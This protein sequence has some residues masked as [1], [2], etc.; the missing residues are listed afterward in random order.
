MFIR[1]QAFYA[2]LIT[3]SSISN[4]RYNAAVNTY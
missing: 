2:H 4:L 1:S 3:D